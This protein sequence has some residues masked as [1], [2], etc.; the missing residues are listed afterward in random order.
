MKKISVLFV[1]TILLL[2]PLKSLAWGEKGHDYVA[3]VAFKQLDKK[4]KKLILSYLDGMSIDEAA[5]WMD[6]IKKDRSYD[7]LKPLHYVNFE[8]G[9]AVKDTCCDN[10]IATLNET[11]A[12]LKN[13]K[14]LS[15]EEVKVQ[16]CYLFHL[17]GDLHQPLHVGYGSD[18]GGNSYQVQFNGKGTNL[19]GLFDY[20]IIE[21]ENIKLKDCLRVKKYSE[22]E[23]KALQSG[24]VVDWAIESRSYLQGI[25]ATNGALLTSDYVTANSQLIK[26]QILKGGIR[27][28]GL[29]NGIFNQA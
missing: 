25:Y 14:S 28:A 21:S 3:E 5:N 12:K 15:K 1:L 26:N 18:K 19:H 27:L 4:T 24:S 20:G 13:Y 6:A 29:L 2:S 7:K 8:K 22:E 17:I 11:I 10:I 9:V 23:I 16:L